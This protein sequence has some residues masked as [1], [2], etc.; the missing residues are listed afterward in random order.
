MYSV[1]SVALAVVNGLASVSSPW[2]FAIVVVAIAVAVAVIFISVAHCREG[3]QDCL[4]FS[5]W[6]VTLC[7]WVFKSWF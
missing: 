2:I 5:S 3:L 1:S 6:V 7:N 4:D